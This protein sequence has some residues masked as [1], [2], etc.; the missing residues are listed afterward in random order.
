MKTEF[1]LLRSTQSTHK[2]GSLI[3]I[4]VEKNFV[5]GTNFTKYLGVVVDELGTCKLIYSKRSR[6][7]WRHETCEELLSKGI[8]NNATQSIC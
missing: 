3:A 5:R 8:A 4:R 1:M 6:K 2:F 7:H